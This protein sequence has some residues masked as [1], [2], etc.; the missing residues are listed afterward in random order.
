MLDEE[1]PY[2]RATSKS[3]FLYLKQLY[4]PGQLNFGIEAVKR[5]MRDANRN[6][7]FRQSKTRQNG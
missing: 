7:P 4:A 5:L 3:L 1:T 2:E 6:V